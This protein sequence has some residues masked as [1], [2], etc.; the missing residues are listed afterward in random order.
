M[1]E[2]EWLTCVRPVPMLAQ[3]KDRAGERKLRLFACACCRR[4]GN[5]LRPDATRQALDRAERCAEDA[6]VTWAH[7]RSL[8]QAGAAEA[9]AARE[10]TRERVRQTQARRGEV[11]E[12]AWVG[13]P[14]HPSQL[15]RAAA[16]AEESLAA[17][18]EAHAVETAARA[19]V[20]VAEERLDPARVAETAVEAQRLGRQAAALA[21]RARRWMHRADQEA[22]RLVPRG[23]AG[24]RAARAAHW[25]EHADETAEEKVS[26]VIARADRAERRSQAE[27]L[28]D[29]FG[30][31]WRPFVIDPA[32]LRWR[33]GAVARVAR[34]IHA[35]K[36]FAD[37]PVLADALEEAGC[38]LPEVLGHCRRP[39]SHVLG[40][41]LLDA[42]LGRT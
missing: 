13:E 22:E 33:D 24:L 9:E 15:V 37:L 36:R 10:P 21:A 7:V 4:L 28:R 23:R 31:P 2:S 20:Q 35:E 6:A 41:A 29:L 11:W 18:A 40:C 5:L 34:S 12:S 19:V 14:P 26:Q 32:W 8:A 30:N 1:T 25:I 17:D 16:E 42:I 38:A 39:G 3:V 27:L